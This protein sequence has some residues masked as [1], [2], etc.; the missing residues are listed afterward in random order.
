LPSSELGVALPTSPTA[1]PSRMSGCSTSF[2]NAPACSGCTRSTSGSWNPCYPKA[3]PRGVRRSD[4][5]DGFGGRLLRHKKKQP[6]S[7]RRCEPRWEDERS[8][9]DRAVSL[10]V[11]RSTRSGSGCGSI[12][13]ESCWCRWSLGCA[14]QSWRRRLLKPSVIYCQRRWDWYPNIIVADM[15][16]IEAGAKRQLRET[17]ASRW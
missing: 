5:C 16:Y 3:R 15:G 13:G 6:E 1:T 11:I 14:G 7:T 4:R 17:G 12:G 10:S 8:N 2:G 9:A